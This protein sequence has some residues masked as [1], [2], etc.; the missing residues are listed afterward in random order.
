MWKQAKVLTN[1]VELART[2][3]NESENE[4]QNILMGEAKT[5]N[6]MMYGCVFKLVLFI[7]L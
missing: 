1:S 5:E 3:E 6:E 4:W 7:F 2:N